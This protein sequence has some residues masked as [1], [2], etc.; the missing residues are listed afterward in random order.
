MML[1]L[2]QMNLKLN[3]I[4]NIH[5]SKVTDTKNLKLNQI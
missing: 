1:N 4:W 2:E 3:L 5:Q